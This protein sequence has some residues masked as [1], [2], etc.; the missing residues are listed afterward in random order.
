MRLGAGPRASRDPRSGRSILLSRI[1]HIGSL[2]WHMP[3]SANLAFRELG[4]TLFLA[5]VGLKAGERFFETVFTLEGAVWLSA[6]VLVAMAPL[7]LVG[8]YARRVLRLD[9]VTLTGLLA[10]STTDPPALAFA[11]SLAGSDAPTV[12]YATVYPLTMLLRILVAQI[13][14]LALCG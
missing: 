9:F 1:G 5:C 3:A 7:V 10:G 14:A 11:G 13:L 8:A 12:A 2:V 4:I 6:A